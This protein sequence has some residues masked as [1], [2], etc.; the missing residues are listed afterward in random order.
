M[1]S[2]RT[3][4][5]ALISAISC[6]LAASAPAQS[7]IQNAGFEQ[8]SPGQAPP[9]WFI[10]QPVLDAGY[11]VQIS[12]E[13]AKE[14]KQ[15]AVITLNGTPGQGFGNMMQ[16]FDAKPYR[17]KKMRFRAAVRFESG[18]GFGQAQLWMRVDRAGG[19]QGFFNNMGDRP[20]RSENWA[21]YDVT[22][23]I[24][25]DA[26]SINIGM[27]M[28]GGGKAWIDAASFQDGDGPDAPVSK[29]TPLTER[30]LDNLVAFTKLLGYVRHFHPSNA[31]EKADWNAFAIAGVAAVEDAKDPADLALKLENFFRPL[32]P[33]VRVYLTSRPPTIKPLVPP[34]DSDGLQVVAWENV[35]FG[36]GVT[37]PNQN[38]YH[39]KR[40]FKDA[41]AGVIPAGFLDPRKPFVADLGAGVSCSVPLAL[42]ATN[43]SALPHTVD[44][45]TIELP[46]QNQSGDD[47]STRLADIALAW[48]VYEHFYPYFDAVKTDWPAVLRQSLTSAA[49]DS[50]QRAFLDT[51]RRLVASARDGH[52][53]VAHM[54]DASYAQ[55]PIA[56]DWIE[57]KLI[58]TEVG[59]GVAK[60]L[61]GDEIV[62][63]DGKAVAD[64]WKAAEPMIAGATEQWRRYRGKSVLLGGPDGSSVGLDAARGSADP[65]TVTLKRSLGS[66]VV[67]KRP[68]AIEEIKPGIWYVDLDGP[69][70]KMEDYQKM[71]PTLAKA[72][73]IVFDMRGYPN[74][75]AMDVLH[76]ISDKPVTSAFWNIPNITK[77]DH[78][79][80]EFIQS[81]WPLAGPLDPRFTGKIAFMTDG[82]AISYAESVMGMV[83]YYK[84]GEVVGSTTAGTNGNINPFALPGGYTVIFTGMKVVRHDGTTHHGV[85][86]HPTVPVDRTVAG[87]AA[88]RDEVLEKAIKVVGG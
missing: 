22:G 83:E 86:I 38:A 40:V 71:M 20:I 5:F 14:G 2:P 70:A 51:L 79:E 24:D 72:K 49:T 15:C 82:R 55:P 7:P 21:F 75:V 11:V 47:R 16:S 50:G 67:E 33:T 30:G 36:G 25:S 1:K 37:P 81:R 62:K 65:F 61:P 42:F 60:L 78:Q 48:N 39:S 74:E 52:G 76:R 34:S 69:R 3:I 54:S 18:G 27:L 9:G 56:A 43:G 64:L 88:G 46:A 12:S 29:P 8:G 35:G 68:K 23:V 80:M 6:L 59:P 53:F 26:E 45:K 58:V 32:A 19:G 85:G 73:G 84:L 87:V 41:P 44:P 66:S 28:V 17:G 77:P 31:V 57:G 63:I 10:P 4:V 13:N